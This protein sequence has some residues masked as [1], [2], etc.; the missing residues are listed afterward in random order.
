MYPFAP[1]MYQND[2]YGS[3]DIKITNTPIR[4]FWKP[5]S[6]VLNNYGNSLKEV[7]LNLSLI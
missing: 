2:I 7:I 1:K 4:V 6:S 3:L 5:D